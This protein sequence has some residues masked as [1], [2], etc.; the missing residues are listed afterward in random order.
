MEQRERERWVCVYVCMCLR[1]RERDESVCVCVFE[2]EREWAFYK[3]I[4]NKAWR[5]CATKVML[6]AHTHVY[7]LWINKYEYKIKMKIKIKKTLEN[8]FLTCG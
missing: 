4:S 6:Y 5:V 1:E 7:K 8:I 3:M 2:R